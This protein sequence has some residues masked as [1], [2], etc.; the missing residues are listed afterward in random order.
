MKLR[1]RT[2]SQSPGDTVVE[3]VEILESS[4]VQ[5]SQQIL[6]PHKFDQD[7]VFKLAETRPPGKLTDIEMIQKLRLEKMAIDK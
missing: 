1:A 3:V 7:K 4:A 2:M 6:E 5:S